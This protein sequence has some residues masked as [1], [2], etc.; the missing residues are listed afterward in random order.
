MGDRYIVIRDLSIVWTGDVSFPGQAREREGGRKR[1]PFERERGREGEEA[2]PFPGQA[3]EVGGANCKHFYSTAAKS[4]T[5]LWLW[6]SLSFSLSFH[7]EAALYAKWLA[8]RQERALCG[9]LNVHAPTGLVTGALRAVCR[10]DDLFLLQGICELS[11][12][13]Y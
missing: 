8:E 12:H 9:Q 1:E 2:E 5:L 7:R 3:R 13:F 10:S 4:L 11:F 6:L